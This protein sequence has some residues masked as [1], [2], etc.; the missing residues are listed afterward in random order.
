MSD[1]TWSYAPAE[2]YSKL[3]RVSLVI[4]PCHFK[5][6]SCLLKHTVITISSPRGCDTPCP[7]TDTHTQYVKWSFPLVPS[8]SVWISVRSKF[9]HEVTSSASLIIHNTN[10]V[11][12]HVTKSTKFLMSVW[13]QPTLCSGKTYI[14]VENN[15]VFTG[16]TAGKPLTTWERKTDEWLFVFNS[17]RSCWTLEKM[18]IRFDGVTWLCFIKHQWIWRACG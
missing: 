12:T 18:S 8:L 11:V 6:L 14:F 10:N 7:Y 4:P 13:E 15:Q 3:Q 16:T 5:I 1:S 17:V 9:S 2:D